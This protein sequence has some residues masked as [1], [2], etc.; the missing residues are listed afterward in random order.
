MISIQ[1]S[2]KHC[3]VYYNNTTL[4]G[5][6]ISYAWYM[7]TRTNNKRYNKLVLFTKIYFVSYL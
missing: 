2:L 6:I 1:V 5:K 3:S 4:S 7:S